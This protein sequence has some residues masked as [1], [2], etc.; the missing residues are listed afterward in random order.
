MPARKGLK[1]KAGVWAPGAWSLKRARQYRKIRDAQLA[2][3]VSYKRAKAIAARVVN[4]TRSKKGEVR[5][6]RG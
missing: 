6:R 4:K 5:K 1:K 2:R 3:G